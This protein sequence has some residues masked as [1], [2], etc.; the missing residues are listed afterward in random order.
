MST[1]GEIEAALPQ[2]TDEELLRL[3]RSLHQ[4]YRERHNVAMYDDNY[5]LYTEADL[6]ASAEQAFLMYDREEEADAKRRTR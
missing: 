6:I 1:L 5:G 4:V 3:N 2:L